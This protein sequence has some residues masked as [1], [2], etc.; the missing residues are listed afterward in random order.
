M[1]DKYLN[2]TNST[3]LYKHFCG[4]FPVAEKIFC[5]RVS[6]KSEGSKTVLPI[7]KLLFFSVI[8]LFILFEK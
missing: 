2:K 7:L 1:S 3:T 5:H 4:S 8:K 6:A